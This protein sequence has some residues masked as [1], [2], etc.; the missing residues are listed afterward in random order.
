MRGPDAAP[1]PGA[2]PERRSWLPPPRATSDRTPL[3][4]VRV[5]V[6]EARYYEDI[7]DELLAAPWPRSQA[8]GR[9]T[10]VST[11]RGRARDPRDDRLALDDR[12]AAGRPYDASWRSAA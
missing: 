2:Q 7:A 4:G 3:P 10:V 6:V 8:A 9:R 5:L 11:V 1:R 12:G